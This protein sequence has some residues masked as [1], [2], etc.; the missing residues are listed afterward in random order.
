MPYAEGHDFKGLS[1]SK[2]P[3]H[4]PLAHAILDE[5]CELGITRSLTGLGFCEVC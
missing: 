3:V 2:T 5:C 1:R 4:K